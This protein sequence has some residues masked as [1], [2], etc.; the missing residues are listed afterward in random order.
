MLFDYLSSSYKTDEIVIDELHKNVHL[1]HLPSPKK[2]NR[3]ILNNACKRK[4]IDDLFSRL[5]K[6]ILKELE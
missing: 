1:N 2:I 3:Q 4:A 5:T 6:V